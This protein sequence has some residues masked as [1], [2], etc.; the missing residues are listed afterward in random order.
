[1]ADS[2]ISICWPFIVTWFIFALSTTPAGHTRTFSS[3]V[4]S[5]SVGKRR[6]PRLLTVEAAE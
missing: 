1:M 3:A 2:L 5:S 6:T 4:G